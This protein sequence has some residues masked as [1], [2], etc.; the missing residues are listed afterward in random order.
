MSAASRTCHRRRYRRVF[1]ASASTAS[2]N[3]TVRCARAVVTGTTLPSL[4]DNPPRGRESTA[5]G[6]PCG[7][8]HSAKSSRPGGRDWSPMPRKTSCCC[9]QPASDQISK[10]EPWPTSQTCL[11]NWGELAQFRGNEQTP[12]GIQ[13]FVAGITDQ[14]TLDRRRLQIQAGCRQHFVPDGCPG[15]RRIKQKAAM[16][17]RRQHE[18]AVRS[19]QQ[20]LAVTSRY[21]KSPLDIETQRCRSLKHQ[22]CTSCRSTGNTPSPHF[23]P[24]GPH[25]KTKNR[26]K[27]EVFMQL[28]SMTTRT[29]SAFSRKNT[30]KILFKN[31]EQKPL[32]KVVC[33]ENMQKDRDASLSLGKAMSRR[34]NNSGETPKQKAADPPGLPPFPDYCSSPATPDR[35][36]PRE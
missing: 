5:Y 32:V 34:K 16:R 11:S 26:A 14:Q 33:H 31:N 12:G 13:G 19:S 15:G 6:R 1:T 30:N 23:L 25:F 2:R 22:I 27:Q 7:G 24:L 9:C 8:A 10:C 18:L 20:R 3:N 28:S 4:R 29:Y 36:W 35:P 21:G 17:M